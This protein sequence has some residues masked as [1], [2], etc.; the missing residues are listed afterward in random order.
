MDAQQNQQ[1]LQAFYAAYYAANRDRIVAMR[2]VKIRNQ[3]AVVP[4]D[5][6]NS[7]SRILQQHVKYVDGRWVVDES[8]FN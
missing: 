2:Y 4:F 6:A 8:S 3:R 5:A 1:Q 7:R